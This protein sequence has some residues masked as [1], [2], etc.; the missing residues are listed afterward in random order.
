[1]KIKNILISQPKPAIANS[2]YFKIAEKY[3]LKIDFNP[4]VRTEVKSL[5]EF[6]ESKIEIKNHTAFIFY[7]KIAIDHFFT[8]CKEAK[9]IPNDE[10]KYFCLTEAIALYLQKYITYRKRKVFYGKSTVNSL[11]DE[12]KKFPNEKFLISL[13]ESYKQEIPEALDA[14]K[15]AYTKAIFFR[16]VCAN[17]SGLDINKYDM[18]LFFSPIGITSLKVNFPN[19]EQG[20]KIIGTLGE[21]TAKTAEELGL[22]VTVKAPTPEFLS[23]FDA[24]ENFLKENKD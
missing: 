9:I 23:I 22:K 19:F 11:I 8:I 14:A 17:M 16:A 21:K 20:E 2:P 10:W 5:I 6:N 4:F 12:I 3:K 13:P 1:M 24:L 18:L 7:S 15:I